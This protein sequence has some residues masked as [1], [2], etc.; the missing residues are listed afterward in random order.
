MCF[1]FSVGHRHWSCP[2]RRTNFNWLARQTQHWGWG[3]VIWWHYE[4]WSTYKVSM[5]MTVVIIKGIFF[6]VLLNA[7]KNFL[8][9]FWLSLDGR[10]LHA[11]N[12]SGCW[13]RR[14]TPETWCCQDTGFWIQIKQVSTVLHWISIPINSNTLLFWL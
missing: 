11:Q 3:V 13:S 2:R 10:Y 9:S 8:P 6:T 12:T 5:S 7:I 4:M 14:G 1:V